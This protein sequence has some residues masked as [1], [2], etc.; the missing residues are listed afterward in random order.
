M[1]VER[2]ENGNW[3]HPARLPLGGGW[4]GY[5]TAHENEHHI[6]DA[7]ALERFCNLG[8]AEGCERLPQNRVWDAL[9]FGVQ[10][11]NG[12]QTSSTKRELLVRYVCERNHLPVE[13]GTLEFDLD[14][15]RWSRMHPDQRVQ[16]MADCFLQFYLARKKL[17]FSAAAENAAAE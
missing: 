11:A 12:S 8:Y 1:P 16:K 7:T 15:W 5:C 6:P 3:S 10:A 2:I 14:G 4:N 9:R 13:D 17:K